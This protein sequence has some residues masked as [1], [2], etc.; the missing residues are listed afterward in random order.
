L[1]LD[2]TVLLY[3]SEYQYHYAQHRNKYSLYPPIEH[4]PLYLSKFIE[5]KPLIGNLEDYEDESILSYCNI[6]PLIDD[7]LNNSVVCAKQHSSTPDFILKKKYFLFF[8][9]FYYLLYD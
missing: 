8:I 3:I 9:Y 2:T 5:R 4:L 7:R 6:F 1:I